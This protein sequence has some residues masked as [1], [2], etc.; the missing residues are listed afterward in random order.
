MFAPLSNGKWFD[1]LVARQA[2]VRRRWHS[3][4]VEATRPLKFDGGLAHL[5]RLSLLACLRRTALRVHSNTPPVGPSHKFVESHSSL[6]HL[7]RFSFLVQ[8][9][10][11]AVSMRHTQ[12][13]AC[14]SA[15][16]LARGRVHAVCVRRREQAAESSGASHLA[17]QDS[18]LPTLR[19][20]ATQEK[21]RLVWQIT[22]PVPMHPFKPGRISS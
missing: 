21:V 10:A 19:V 2:E 6:P 17:W 22:S 13:L 5:V 18:C 4:C 20:R 12:H 8:S 9:S 15:A 11:W 3:A 16:W 14:R 1:L 7:R